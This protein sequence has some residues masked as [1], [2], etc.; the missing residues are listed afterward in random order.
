[1]TAGGLCASTQGAVWAALWG[2]LLLVVVVSG[3][4]AGW[5]LGCSVALPGMARLT[6]WSAAARS[7]L[8]VLS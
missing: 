8:Q 6:S 1:M 5:G 3:R 7:T 4:M 2:L